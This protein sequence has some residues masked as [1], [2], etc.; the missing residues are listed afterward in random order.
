MSEN[1]WV[2]EVSAAPA[3]SGG[4]F[5]MPSFPN[6][7]V[8]Y[9]TD[10]AALAALQAYPHSNSAGGDGVNTAGFTW[11]APNPISLN[12][13]IA[14][15]DWQANAKRAISAGSRLGAN[16]TRVERLRRYPGC[17]TGKRRPWRQAS[18]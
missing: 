9:F 5:P 1:R 12:T 7:E 14:K 10:P 17:G 16:K 6:L 2:R 8:A 4:G 13:Y 3:H 15:I 18:R 11:S